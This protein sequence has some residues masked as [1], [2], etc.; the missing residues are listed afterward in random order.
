MNVKAPVD[1]YE[2]VINEAE[3][4]LEARGFTVA[5]YGIDFNGDRIWQMER[6]PADAIQQFQN[7]LNGRMSLRI[8]LE[9]PVADDYPGHDHPEAL[10]HTNLV[11]QSDAD[12]GYFVVDTDRYRPLVSEEE[13]DRWRAT[14]ERALLDADLP[15]KLGN[16]L[17]EDNEVASS[18][19]YYGE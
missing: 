5:S 12:S 9:E 8:T 15:V 13:A 2:Q 18:D 4:A 16:F 3:Q 11:Y 17:H 14:I 10:Y 19:L 7:D 1:Q 6:D